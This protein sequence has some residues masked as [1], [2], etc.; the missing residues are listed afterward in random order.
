MSY[1]PAPLQM[2]KCHAVISTSCQLLDMEMTEEKYTVISSPPVQ[3]VQGN[4]GQS[5]LSLPPH[6]LLGSGHFLP[7]LTVPFPHLIS[8][9]QASGAFSSLRVNK[10]VEL[11]WHIMSYFKFMHCQ[12]KSI[13]KCVKLTS[14]DGSVSLY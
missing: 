1:H 6:I 2:W 14:E 8:L 13:F 9:I 5:L 3:N 12:C 4:T 11:T 10:V 7:L